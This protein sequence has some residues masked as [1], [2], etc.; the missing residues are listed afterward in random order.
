MGAR[1]LAGWTGSTATGTGPGSAS[2]GSAPTAGSDHEKCGTLNVD[3]RTYTDWTVS[4]NRTRTR[5]SSMSENI[6]DEKKTASKQLQPITVHMSSAHHESSSPRDRVCLSLG[7]TP[8]PGGGGY[9]M[10]LA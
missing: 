6:V 8:S 9:I 7:D 5:T 2:P 10:K 4:V 3:P 1:C